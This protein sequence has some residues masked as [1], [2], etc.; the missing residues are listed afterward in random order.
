MHCE[1]YA[2]I[3]GVIL[4][5]DFDGQLSL[6]EISGFG[7]FVLGENWDA[8]AAAH[9]LAASEQQS[10]WEGVGAAPNGCL[11][12]S[13]PAA[14]VRDCAAVSL[15]HALSHA[16]SYALRDKCLTAVPL[17]EFDEFC[18]FLEAI[19]GLASSGDGRSW[20]HAPS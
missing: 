5:R 3:S 10:V 15:S 20:P 14:T 2:F 1:D 8:A 9:M 18:L 19:D 4:P 7:R 12:H 11:V 6:E 13:Q 16:L 17:Q